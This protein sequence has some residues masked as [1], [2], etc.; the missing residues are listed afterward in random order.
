[1]KIETL[2]QLR[3]TSTLRSFDTRRNRS[4]C[5]LSKWQM[6]I[7]LVF[8]ATTVEAAPGDITTLAGSGAY[9]AATAY[10]A[11]TFGGDGGAATAAGLSNPSG[12]AVDA[13]GNVYIADCGNNRVRKVNTSGIID[14]VAGT[15][16]AGY[17]GDGGLA[18]NAA[19]GCPFGVAM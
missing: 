4:P 8:V 9:N 19:L 3:G 16:V 12:V 6:A 10:V 17:S 2:S 15:G 14:T 7:A 18:T 1:M 13:A 5:K 11:P